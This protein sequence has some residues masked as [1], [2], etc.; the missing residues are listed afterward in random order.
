MPMP[1]GMIELAKEIGRP[2]LYF[3]LSLIILVWGAR[4]YVG[5]RQSVSK[6]YR[7]SVL[8]T[9]D[10]INRIQL[11]SDKAS[12]FEPIRDELLRRLGVVDRRLSS[13]N[14]HMSRNDSLINSFLSPEPM[15]ALGAASAFVMMVTNIIGANFSIN[16]A[17]T[18][19][20][21][22]LLSALWVFK[23]PRSWL[24]RVLYY[25]LI[26]TAI[27]A[28]ASGLNMVGLMAAPAVRNS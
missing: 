3:V 4:S 2:A 17:Y 6:D 12:E 27:Y 9:L 20:I 26:A 23:S 19:C 10:I 15:L 28:M 16:R 8:E 5:I 11:A 21:L 25:V 18:A 14:M 1:T 22:S 24:I 13:A 7:E